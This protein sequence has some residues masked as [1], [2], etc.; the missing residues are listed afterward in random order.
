MGPIWSR[1]DPGGPH[2]DPMKLAIRDPSETFPHIESREVVFD[3]YLSF[4]NSDTA[5]P[6][7]KFQNG[8]ITKIWERFIKS[9]PKKYIISQ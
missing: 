2:V 4:S 6:C 1:Q 3:Q 8:L 5:V 9:G 7:A